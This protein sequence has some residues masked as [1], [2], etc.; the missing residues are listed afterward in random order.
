M[1]RTFI[2]NSLLAMSIHWCCKLNS[3]TRCWIKKFPMQFLHKRQ[4]FQNSPKSCQFARNF[5]AKNFQKSPNQVTLKLNKNVE[6]W[7]IFGVL[8]NSVPIKIVEFAFVV[9]WWSLSSHIWMKN[10]IKE[11]ICKSVRLEGVSCC[12]LLLCVMHL[13]QRYTQIEKD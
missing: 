6:Y 13:S 10:S 4:V 9:S 7:T 8:E 11:I 5:V 12:V 2:P 1:T 3:V